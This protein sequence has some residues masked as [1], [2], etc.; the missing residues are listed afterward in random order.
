MQQ[1]QQQQQ[2]LQQQEDTNTDLRV[3]NTEQLNTLGGSESESQED[4]SESETSEE[5]ALAQVKKGKMNQ[6]IKQVVNKNNE[7]INNEDPKGNKKVHKGHLILKNMVKNL[8]NT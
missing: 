3:E 5:N 4:Q 1:Q 6:K 8:N 2:R 7:P